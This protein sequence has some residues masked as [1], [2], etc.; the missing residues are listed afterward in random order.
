MFTGIISDIGVVTSITPSDKGLHLSVRVPNGFLGDVAL[1]DSIATS[2]ACLT[3][4]A[5]DDAHFF[6]D[7]S[8]ETLAKTTLGAWRVGD[9]VN[10][11]KAMR[12]DSRFGGHIV[13]GHVDG[14]G[15]IVR[16]D[17]TALAWQVKLEIPQAFL[18]YVAPKGSIAVDGISL[19]TN[20]VDEFVHL[21]I[22]PHSVD[23]TTISAWCAGYAVNIEIDLIARYLERL[24][25]N[26]PP[27]LDEKF[28]QKHGF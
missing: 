27:V 3:V 14:V 5:Q 19:T 6:A 11:E 2:G 24:M 21:T 10:L 25:A 16:V 9:N 1:G 20:Q 23:K 8:H 4:V 15:K 28:L 12:A 7:V 13:A 22:I 17:K 18:R 26:T